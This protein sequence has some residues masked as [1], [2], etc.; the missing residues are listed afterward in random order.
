MYKR[1]ARIRGGTYDREFRAFLDAPEGVVYA[2]QDRSWLQDL[3]SV[4]IRH[5]LRYLDNAYRR[6]HKVQAPAL[7]L[8]RGARVRGGPKPTA[9]PFRTM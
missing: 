5:A 3:P 6:F 8:G 2:D 1:F 9:S 7:H 4:P